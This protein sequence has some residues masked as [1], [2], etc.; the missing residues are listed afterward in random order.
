M[1]VPRGHF[2]VNMNI[3]LGLNI[4]LNKTALF[5]V[6]IHRTNLSNAVLWTFTIFITPAQSVLVIVRKLKRD[7]PMSGRTRAVT[8]PA[9]TDASKNY[10]II[11]YKS[12]SPIL[13]TYITCPFLVIWITCSNADIFLRSKA[14]TPETRAVF[15][16]VSKNVSILQYVG[17]NLRKL[18][19]KYYLWGNYGHPKSLK[20]CTTLIVHAL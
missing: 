2:T 9:V 12:Y 5:N 19:V 8:R 20:L 17:K 15:S 6:Q 3:Q 14:A 11:S 18:N 13:F 7:W 4:H 1:F 10:Q 16:R